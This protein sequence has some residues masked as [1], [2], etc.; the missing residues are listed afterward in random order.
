MY[1]KRWQQRRVLR[2][3]GVLISACSQRGCVAPGSG[4][5]ARGADAL[6]DR[7]ADHAAVPHSAPTSHP[8]PRRAP[9]EMQRLH[10]ATRRTQ[11][12]ARNAPHA[13]RR[14]QRAARNAPHATRRT[15]RASRRTQRASR[16]A[17]RGDT[18][19]CQ[20]VLYNSQ[21]EQTRAKAAAALTHL[22][23][24]GARDTL[25]RPR[26]RRRTGC[27][28]VLT[29]TCVRAR[30][31]ARACLRGWVRV[32]VSCTCAD[33]FRNVRRGA[34]WQTCD[35]APRGRRATWCPV[36]DLLHLSSGQLTMTVHKL[37]GLMAADEPTEANSK[38]AACNLTAPKP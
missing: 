29:H 12:A 13:T 33:G 6:D 32:C 38:P 5:C 8:A 20:R 28:C 7:R 27:G 21:D 37:L 23:R 11:R 4:R 9:R 10:R 36:A 19:Q 1:F 25:H 14:T 26:P 24:E 35:V 17:W 15:Q 3:R 34:P 18:E 16:S 31:C 22:A 30:V 2:P